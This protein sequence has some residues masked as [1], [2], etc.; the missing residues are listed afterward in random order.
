M[1]SANVGFDLVAASFLGDL[2]SGLCHV[3]LSLTPKASLGSGLP[4]LLVL[5][6]MGMVVGSPT[7]L[8]GHFVVSCSCWVI[9]LKC[10]T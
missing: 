6:Y 1:F 7:S 3:V 8:K 2:G 10:S 9:K 5:G 4:E